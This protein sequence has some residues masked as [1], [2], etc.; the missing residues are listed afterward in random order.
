M[1]TLFYDSYRVLTEVYSSG[2][3]IK[4]A[5]NDV[6][7]DEKNRSHLTKIC[8]GV[9][10]KD[11]TLE[12]DISALC[13]KRPKQ[14]VR[15][16]LKIGMYSIA[17]LKTAV[18]AVTDNLVELVK[19]LG[20]GANA[21]FVNAFL[22]KYAKYQRV[23]P[24]DG[25][26]NLSVKYSYPEF[27]V[28]KLVADYGKEIAE[29]IMNA[30]EERTAV[31]F[32]QGI[33]GEAYLT[34]RRWDY[35]KTP[36]AN[37]FFVKGFKVDED[38]YKGVYTFQ[39]IGSVAI[40]DAVG[41]G[42]TLLD[43]CS[44]PGGKS[45]NLADK[46]ESVTAFELHPHRVK[47]I[48]EYTARMGK[49]NVVAIQKDSS[50]LDEN[51]IEKFDV[52]LCDCPCSGYGVIKDNPDVKLRRTPEDIASLNQIQYEILSTCSKYVKKGGSLYYSTCSVFKC[53]NEDICGKFLK[54][55]SDFTEE[56]ISSPLA[57]QRMKR[58][59]SFLPDLSFGAGFFICKF[60]KN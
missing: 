60:T 3:F 39:S 36:F 23:Y 32:N 54:F 55:N 33:D 51:Y 26:K 52:V 46:F 59:I 13:D 14:A 12:Y 41:G 35:E 37:T 1:L 27:A 48:E 47:L 2:A 18:Y 25:I 15:T 20:K 4:Q 58:G 7:I 56:I 38:F 53:E 40:C 6:Q 10:D 8:Y 49:K 9:L 16:L 11:I 34:E 45:V 17:Y 29:N 19:K 50:V 5:L 21:G 42:K 24:I 43:A 44:A 57:N 28:K 31:R 30:D 22:R